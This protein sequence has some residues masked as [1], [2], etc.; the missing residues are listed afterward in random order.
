MK[1]K[2]V[3]IGGGRSEKTIHIDRRIV[4]LSEKKNPKLLFIPTASSDDLKYV[5]YIKKQ[6][7]DTLGCKM[8]VMYLL[9]QKYTRAE[10]ENMVSSADIIYVGG[11]NT[12]MMMKLWRRIGLDKLI[13]KAWKAGTVMCGLS[14]GSICWYESGHSDSM[15]YYNEQ[16]W[17]YIRVRCLDLLPFIHC[18]HYDSETG[19]VKRRE[20]FKGM[21]KKFPG[22]IGITCDDGV[23]IE[24]LN[25]EF[26]VLS[27]QTDSHA[28][29]VF[30][31]N[32]QFHE[33]KLENRN[34]FLPI[35]ELS[36][37]L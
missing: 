2:I 10:L 28:Y 21:L 3:T 30:W 1:T 32:G 6:Y 12:L 23:A 35:K 15:W 37:V 29:K 33:L 34:D 9:S 13:K 26:R 22:K 25:D 8:E 24:Y 17:D 31:K 4:E 27:N 16:K 7:V 18:P 19:G 20:S 36:K 14:A 5:E 11:G